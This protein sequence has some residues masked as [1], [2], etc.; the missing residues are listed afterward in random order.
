L[1]NDAYSSA[2]S[3]PSLSLSQ[4]RKIAWIMFCGSMNS[5][6]K[7]PP[8]TIT[9]NASLWLRGVAGDYSS[10]SWSSSPIPSIARFFTALPLP[11]T[12]QT[13]STQIGRRLERNLGEWTCAKRLR[14]RALPPRAESHCCLSSRDD[15]AMISAG[16]NSVSMSKRGQS[17]STAV[18]AYTSSGTAGRCVSGARQPPASS[19]HSPSSRHRESPPGPPLTQP[20]THRSS[21]RPRRQR[22]TCAACCPRRHGRARWSSRPPPPL[23]R[24]L[25]TRPS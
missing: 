12:W 5:L 3:A 13:P 10:W 15:A 7:R 21:T 6:R 23:V 20:P 25:R 11:R 16:S 4:S 1:R 2:F 8:Q 24:L 19:L 18:C 17:N 14:P 9:A 22:C